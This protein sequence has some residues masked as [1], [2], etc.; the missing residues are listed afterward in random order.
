MLNDTDCAIIKL[1]I[2]T[3]TMS[4]TLR[5][6]IN[7]NFRG[8]KCKAKIQSFN[9]NCTLIPQKSDTSIETKR[10]LVNYNNIKNPVFG[11]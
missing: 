2:K 9:I 7:A 4:N 11:L 5:K 3:N 6:T 1:W 8:Y 10:L